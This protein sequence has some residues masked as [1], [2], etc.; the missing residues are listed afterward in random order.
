[1][2]HFLD[3]ITSGSVM[4]IF[5]S[6]SRQI[7]VMIVNTENDEWLLSAFYWFNTTQFKS[8][9]GAQA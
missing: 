4:G 7:I 1:M 3:I 8:I 6:T 5:F 2:N 9:T